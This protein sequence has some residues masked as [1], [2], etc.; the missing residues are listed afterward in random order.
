MLSGDIAVGVFERK[1]HVV[2]RYEVT[3][4]KHMCNLKSVHQLI[5]VFQFIQFLI[6]K[7]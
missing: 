6:S 3:G 4:I 5:C 2:L 1:F 7:S